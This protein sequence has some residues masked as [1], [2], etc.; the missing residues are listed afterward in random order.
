MNNEESVPLNH[1]EICRRLQIQTIHFQKRTESGGDHNEEDFF[2][3]INFILDM[4][5]G[6]PSRLKQ[7]SGYHPPKSRS[8]SDPPPPPRL[9]TS[10]KNRF[11]T[12]QDR[13]ACRC[14]P[15]LSVISPHFID[16]ESCTCNSMLEL[17]LSMVRTPH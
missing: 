16:G 4:Q 1:S 7:R 5:P 15:C 10:Y 17:S 6:E 2:R 11:M 9:R 12:N 8:L 14:R 3:R 13:R